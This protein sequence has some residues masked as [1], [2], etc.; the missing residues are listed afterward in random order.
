MTPHN[1]PRQGE[2][3]ERAA[4]FTALIGPL[5]LG[6]TRS[7]SGVDAWP[8]RSPGD[9]SPSFRPGASGRHR[10][11][12]TPAARE[13][14]QPAGTAETAE[15]A[16]RPAEASPVRPAVTTNGGGGVTKTAPS[17]SS[18]AAARAIKALIPLSRAVTGPHPRPTV[19]TAPGAVLSRQV[20]PLCPRPGLEC[21]RVDHFPGGP[22]TG[23]RASACD[24]G[25]TARSAPVA[26]RK[27]HTPTND[28]MARWPDDRKATDRSPEKTMRR[29]PSVRSAGSGPA[30]Q[31]L[32]DSRRLSMERRARAASDSRLRPCE[33]IRQS[34]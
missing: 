19:N 30:A 7:L 18:S 22:V 28:Q 5:E 15:G 34:P 26:F 20:D 2:S 12:R 16:P 23:H 13:G 11:R 24:L 14:P 25:A 31:R 29:Y 4:L 21:D 17:R 9:V 33:Q 1:P 3:G 27:R 8:G 10:D 6:R 32:P